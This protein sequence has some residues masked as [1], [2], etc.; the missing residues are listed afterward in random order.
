MRKRAGRWIRDLLYKLRTQGMSPGKQAAAVGVGVFIGCSPFY[1]LHFPICLVFAR[2]FRLNQGLTYLASQVSL[3]WIWPFLVLAELETGRRL[4]GKSHLAIRFSELRTLDLKQFGADLLL[5]SVVVGAVLAV[6]LAGFTLWATRR[7]QMH[8]EITTLLEETARRY[9]DSGLIHWE[10]VRGKLRYDPVYFNLLRR[11]FLPSEGPAPRPR[12]RPRDRLRPAPRRP[13]D[14]S[15]GGSTLR[16]G[17][18]RL[19]I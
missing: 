17:R 16:T 6:L 7:R 13:R 2:L 14:A 8:P 15:A 12:L 18:R 9:M 4:R 1:G 5:G 3:P 19:C 11:G 10:F